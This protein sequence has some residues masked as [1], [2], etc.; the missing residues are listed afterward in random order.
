MVSIIRGHDL[1]M[2][3]YVLLGIDFLIVFA[4]FAGFYTFSFGADTLTQF[5]NPMI[6][7][8]AALTYG[9]YMY[10]FLTRSLYSFGIL[11]TD[12]Y[13]FSWAAF[14]ICTTLFV[15][16]TQL[17][18]YPLMEKEIEENGIIMKLAFIFIT[19]ILVVNGLCCEFL[20]FP[21]MFVVFGMAFFNAGLSIYFYSKK[22]YFFFIFFAIFGCMFYQTSLITMAIMIAAYIYIE[23]GYKI[24]GKL[25]L[26]EFISIAALMVIGVVNIISTS[27]LKNIGIIEDNTRSID[28]SGLKNRLII[29]AHDYKT[30]LSSGL[31]LMPKLYLPLVLTILPFIFAIMYGVKNRKYVVIVEYIFIQFVLSLLAFALNMMEDTQTGMTPRLVYNFYT[32]QV[33]MILI[34]FKYIWEF[35]YVTN[36]L[37]LFTGIYLMAQLLSC[38]L[39]AQN[40]HLSNEIDLMNARIIA[41]EIENYEA[42]TGNTIKYIATYQDSVYTQTYPNVRYHVGA[43]NEKSLGLVTYSLIRYVSGDDELRKIDPDKA[44]YNEYF[45]D[46][47]W[48]CLVP[49][50]QMVFI[51][52]TL[53]YAAY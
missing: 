11:L 37:C 18:F 39:I 45:K 14:V 22:K 8:D 10:Y 2:K 7:I 31:G 36:A 5:T 15:Y 28:T 30:L 16:L 26:R 49:D 46:K 47:D 53:H 35:D 23:G 41:E 19:T 17:S 51:G 32:V 44:V 25:F 40:R 12:Y 9:R 20:M 3:K 34:S 38:N 42:E 1:S 6:N 13:K 29:M 43:I 33:A 50:E 52:D 24:T 48:D 27:V 4:A 21:E